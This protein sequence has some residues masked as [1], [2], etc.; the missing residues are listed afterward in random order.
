MEE[1]PRGKIGWIQIDCSD[2]DRLRA[3]WAALLHLAPDPSP[4]PS[5]YRCLLGRD[6]CPGMCFQRVPESKTV[7]NRVHLDI[8]VS[9]LDAATTRITELGGARR[10]EHADFHEDGWHWRVMADPEGNEFCL[11]PTT[12]GVPS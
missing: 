8:V 3:F 2:P 11:V 9:N 10:G 4:T 7:K 1:G 5:A 6:G 12:E